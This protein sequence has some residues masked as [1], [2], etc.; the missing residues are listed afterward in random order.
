ME[1][2]QYKYMIYIYDIHMSIICIS[3]FPLIPPFK[4]VSTKRAQGKCEHEPSVS[5]F[6]YHER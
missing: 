5:A 6:S 3:I 1:N 2:V 4:K